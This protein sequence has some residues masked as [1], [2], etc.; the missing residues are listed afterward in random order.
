MGGQWQKKNIAYLATLWEK[1]KN[2]CADRKR[3]RLKYVSIKR[4]KIRPRRGKS[5]GKYYLK[6]SW[7]LDHFQVIAFSSSNGKGAP[8]TDVQSILNL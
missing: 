2:T 1:I 4:L 6:M 8:V 5:A 7:R 3:E